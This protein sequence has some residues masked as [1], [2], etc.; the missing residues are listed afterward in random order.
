MKIDVQRLAKL[1]GLDSS[2]GRLMSEGASYEN[3]DEMAYEAEAH[4]LEEA[5]VEEDD[6]DLEE[7][8]EVDERMLVQE[9]RRAKKMLS[10]S[11]QAKSQLQENELKRIIESEVQNVLKD[12]N[13]NSEWI[14]GS[15]KPSRS[16][17][18]YTHQGSFLK[19]LGFK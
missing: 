19:G 9:L 16:K 2:S 4:D 17:S 13:L 11:R 14:Y 18:G 7:M 10:E 6:A 1:A 8:I 12:L 5:D 3:K 15:K